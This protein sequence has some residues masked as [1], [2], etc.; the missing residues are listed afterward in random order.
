MM[1]RTD[2]SASPI[3]RS[4][5]AA[6]LTFVAANGGSEDAIEMRYEDENI[7]LTQKMMAQLY[8]VEVHTI[9][10]HIKK[11]FADDELQEAATI[12]K[13]RIVQTEGSRQVSRDVL[14]YN[15]QMI[16]AVGFKVNNDRAVQFRKWANLSLIHI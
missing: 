10:E 1:K 14:H 4:S 13:F 5:A 7:W 11:I 15:L 2:E 3:I 8:D 16:I 12:R 9:N 6:Y